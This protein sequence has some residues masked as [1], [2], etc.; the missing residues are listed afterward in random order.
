MISSLF[1]PLTLKKNQWLLGI[2]I[3]GRKLLLQAESQTERNKWLAVLNGSIAAK[4]YKEE[5][6]KNA[7]RP[8]LRLLTFFTSDSTS[9]LH[10]DDRPVSLEAVTVRAS[11]SPTTPNHKTHMTLLFN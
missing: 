2:A 7:S 9:S 8:D 5:A 4:T 6:E 11:L 10:L 1:L 3:E